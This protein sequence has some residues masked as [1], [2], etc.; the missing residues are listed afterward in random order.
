[1]QSWGADKFTSFCASLIM[2]F[3]YFF[4]FPD[5]WHII[6]N[7]WTEINYI[8]RWAGDLEYEYNSFYRVHTLGASY[9][10]FLGFVYVLYLSLKEKILKKKYIILLTLLLTLQ[11]YTYLFYSIAAV[12]M[13]ISALGYVVYHFIRYKNKE[14]KDK[15]KIIL[16]MGLCSALLAIPSIIDTIDLLIQGPDVKDWVARIGGGDITN[17][18]P[19]WATKE[20]FIFGIILAIFSPNKQFMVLA[21]SLIF[22]VL[23]IENVQVLFGF[24][25]QPGHLYH[26]TAMP[27]FVLMGG[28]A[29]YNFITKID[30]FYE[31]LLHKEKSQIFKSL[32][33]YPVFLGAMIFYLYEANHYGY[34]YASKTYHIQ[35][36]T[37]EQS[38]VIK[39]FKS[40]AHQSVVATLSPEIATPLNIYSTSYLYSYFA[41]L[42][43]KTVKNEEIYDRLAIM[44]WLQNVDNKDIDF[45]FSPQGSD[46]E[47]RYPYYYVQ[48][49]LPP[50]TKRD[51]GV[52]LYYIKKRL[53][54]LN[55]NPSP[56]LCENKLDY[57]L[58]GG[59][60]VKQKNFRQFN[61][62]YL[63]LI[64][65]IGTY[66]IYR[67]K[68]EQL[69]CF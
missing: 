21:L 42:L 20:V 44:F 19:F 26:R 50:Y 36:I 10:I 40:H 31:K 22:A 49:F 9:F 45:Y 59:G 55:N 33:I 2:I 51:I 23:L 67:L 17:S 25:V 5:K 38:Q 43:Y 57:L 7:L 66:L 11:F 27:V 63:E 34:S 56:L 24:N 6:T 28:A 29:F 32:I 41:G 8:H 1:M 54:T 58:V 52:M 39:W 64:N 48:R 14:D 15:A 68:T 65:K 60:G 18:T 16:Y 47:K 3:G 61:K 4:L 37:K 35:G 30:Y 12:I 13:Y 46:T 69:N 62:K 53:N